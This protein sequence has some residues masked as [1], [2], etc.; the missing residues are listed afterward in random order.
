MY[1]AS[2]LEADTPSYFETIWLPPVTSSDARYPG[3]TRERWLRNHQ[4]AQSHGGGAQAMPLQFCAAGG[5]RALRVGPVRNAPGRWHYFNTSTLERILESGEPRA[6][7]GVP[8]TEHLV[9]L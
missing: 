3:Y 2:N 6:G 1:L 5:V 7:A 4:R 9:E 8:V